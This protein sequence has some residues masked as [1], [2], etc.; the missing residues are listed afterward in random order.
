M[1]NPIYINQNANRTNQF[2]FTFTSTTPNT[3]LVIMEVNPFYTS[4]V[5]EADRPVR[6]RGDSNG[7]KLNI[8]EA[9]KKIG[10]RK[11]AKLFKVSRSNIR[12]GIKHLRSFRK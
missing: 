12:R 8:L 11:A 7:E 4:P 6:Y 1:S 9:A 3:I 5:K 10:I 2:V